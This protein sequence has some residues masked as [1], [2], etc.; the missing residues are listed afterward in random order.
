MAKEP[1][2]FGV[3][4]KVRRRVVRWVVHRLVG[5]EHTQK[6][7][8]GR[9]EEPPSRCDRSMWVQPRIYRARIKQNRHAIVNIRNDGVRIRRDDCAGLDV[10]AVFSPPSKNRRDEELLGEAKVEGVG[11]PTA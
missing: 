8:W 6:F 5:S 4:A 9:R 1:S 11:I 10:I 3:V 2:F 7:I